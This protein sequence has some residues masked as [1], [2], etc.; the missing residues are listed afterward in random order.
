[1]WSIVATSENEARAFSEKP[2]R[3]SMAEAADNGDGRRRN[4]HTRFSE[5]ANMTTYL[6]Y[7]GDA[8]HLAVGH[9]CITLQDARGQNWFCTAEGGLLE[10]TMDARAVSC[11]L[12]LGLEGDT[13][14]FL[15]A[16]NVEALA[17]LLVLATYPSVAESRERLLAAG[18]Q[19]FREAWGT[20]TL[21][22]IEASN[23]QREIMGE[24]ETSEEAWHRAAEL[25]VG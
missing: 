12:G 20:G 19:T 4:Q 24:G 1:L 11:R 22:R 7:R 9:G 14:H 23:G 13:Y 3:G 17:R 2:S 8:T 18:W 21:N 6:C 16:D 25:G 5:E 15:S 10:D